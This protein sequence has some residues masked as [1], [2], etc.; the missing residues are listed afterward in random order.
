MKKKKNI[1]E[2][3]IKGPFIP[4]TEYKYIEATLGTQDMSFVRNLFQNPDRLNLRPN[5]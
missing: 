4:H 2:I 5:R 3:R 1:R